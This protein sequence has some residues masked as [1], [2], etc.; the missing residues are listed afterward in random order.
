MLASVS[1]SKT[2][3]AIASTDLVSKTAPSSAADAIT[4]PGTAAPTL[5]DANALRPVYPLNC[6]RRGH[7]GIVVLDVT[8]GVDG[9]PLSVDVIRSAGC[10]ELDSSAI[11]AVRRVR[12]QPALCAGRAVTASV[13]QAIRFVLPPK[14]R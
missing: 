12:F 11:D 14:S 3:P 2:S 6:R 10:A 9:A 7:E 13:E 8:V 5:L 1:A 4:G